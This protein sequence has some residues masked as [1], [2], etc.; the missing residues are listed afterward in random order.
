[1]A[2]VA[3]DFVRKLD[4][5]GLS[6]A[7]AYDGR[8][9]Y[10]EAFGFTGRNSRERL[11]TSHLFRIAS[12]SKPITSAAIFGLIEKGRLRSED[13]VFGRYGILGTKYGSPP[14]GHGV[15]QITIDQLLTHTSGGWSNLTNDPMFLNIGLDQA[16]LISWALDNQPLSNPPGKVFAYSNFGYCIL[17]RVIEKV[18]GQPYAEYVRSAILLPSGI[19]DMRIAENTLQKRAERE[20]TYYGQGQGPY[21]DPYAINVRRMDSHGGWIATPVDLV[22]FAMH[23]DGFDRSRNILSPETIRK[24]ATSTAANGRY[25][26]GWNVNEKGHWWHGGDLAGTTAVLV[27]TS[28]RFCW[29]GLT[30]TRRAQSAE[31]IDDM[32]WDLAGKVSA[33]R[34]ALA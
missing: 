7:I 8:L 34:N 14:Y 25:A 24:M 9:V 6:V 32:M 12:V 29:A 21:E 23:V 5:P 10:E 30:N 27:R 31:A 11:T 15:E 18:T 20:V 17:G 33:W 13:R 16:E 19:T 4:A 26:R 3:E 22:R 1:M 28:S 2:A